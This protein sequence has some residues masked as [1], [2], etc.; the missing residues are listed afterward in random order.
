MVVC[1]L[2]QEMT[3]RTEDGE[4]LSK[5][6]D[7][8]IVTHHKIRDIFFLRFL[9][10]RSSV[11]SSTAAKSFRLI[12]AISFSSKVSTGRSIPD[13]DNIYLKIRLANAL[14][15]GIHFPSGRNGIDER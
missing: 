13:I 8:F 6:D 12:I 4:T 2:L 10:R 14:A 5:E 3:L 9:N 11:P 7:T 15:V 1:F